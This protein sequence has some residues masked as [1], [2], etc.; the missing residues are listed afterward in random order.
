METIKWSSALENGISAFDK[1]HKYLVDTLNEIYE[2]LKEN[3]REEAKKVFTERIVNYTVKHFGHE[4][5][6]MK[7]YNYPDYEKHKK[8]HEVFVRIVVEKLIPEIKNGSEY[9]FNNA[10]SFLIGWLSMHICN[11]DRKFNKWFIDN[12]IEIN[13]EPVKL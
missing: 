4:E 8:I 9:D 1:E 13:E 2:L 10:M 3:K 12:G 7:E 5:K 6:I 11:A